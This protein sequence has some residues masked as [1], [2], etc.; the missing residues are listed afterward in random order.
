MFFFLDR[1][2]LAAGNMRSLPSHLVSA[3]FF[4]RFFCLVVFFYE[5]DGTE[6]DI[7]FRLICSKKV[8]LTLPQHIRRNP[9]YSARSPLIAQP[10]YHAKRSYYPNV[11]KRPYTPASIHYGKPKPFAYD[12]SKLPHGGDDFDQGHE[13]VRHHTV[14]HGKGIS[15]GISYGRGYIPYGKIKSDF[16]RYRPGYESFLIFYKF[17]LQFNLFPKV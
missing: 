1:L 16:T 4:V 6:F 10:S 2:H 5:R 12:K 15:H 14:P 11:P 7:L 3:N 8:M 9:A 17:Y 13:P